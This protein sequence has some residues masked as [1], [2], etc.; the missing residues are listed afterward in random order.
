MVEERLLCEAW[1]SD[2]LPDTY[3]L[4]EKK[5]GLE[6]VPEDLLARFREPRLVTTFSLDEERQLARTD[7]ATVM[8]AIRGKGYYLQLP[9]QDNDEMAQMA[10]RND[11]LP[12]R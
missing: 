9:P 2:A 5:T 6:E 7:G 12:R 10:S 3:L 1:A 4:V 8:A 11:K